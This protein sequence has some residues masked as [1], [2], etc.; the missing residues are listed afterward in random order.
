[1]AKAVKGILLHGT[2]GDDAD[3]RGTDGNDTILGFMGNDRIYG[4]GGDDDLRGHEGDDYIEGGLGNDLLMGHDGNDALY[5]GEGADTLYAGYGNDTL[6][7]GSGSDVLWAG[8]DNDSLTGGLGADTFK[9]VENWDPNQSRVVLPGTNVHTIT[10]F[11]RAN[12]DLIDIRAI[13][14]DGNRLTDTRSGNQD[15]HLVNS[16]TGAV[17]EAWM[18]PIYDPISSAQIGVSLYLNYDSDAEA[19]TRIDALG[20]SSLTWGVDILG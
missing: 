2:D 13:D 17:G 5:G 6:N 18:Q 7:G 16:P 10:D 15:F 19:D 8:G 12:G 3:L 1:M 11:S 4:G 14:A 20:V 9:F